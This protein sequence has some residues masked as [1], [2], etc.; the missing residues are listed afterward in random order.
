MASAWEMLNENRLRGTDYLSA[1]QRQARD[2]AANF[3]FRNYVCGSGPAV[4]LNSENQPNGDVVLGRYADG[5]LTTEG[6]AATYNAVRVRVQ[7]SKT[8]NSEVPFFFARIFGI[9]SEASSAEAVAM[10]R[11]GIS[12]FRAT[13]STG[14]TS[15]LPFALDIKEWNKLLA[16]SGPDNWGYDPTSKQIYSG[17]DGV[18]EIKLYPEKKTASGITPGNFGTIDIGGTDNSNSVLKRQI[19]DGVSAED[20]AYHGGEL[21]LDP[22][23]Q[24]LTLNGETGLSVGMDLALPDAV[25]EARTIPLYSKVVSG[26]NTAQFTIVAF[27]GVRILTFDLNGSNKYIMIQPAVVVDDSAI[28]SNSP[29]SYNVYQPVMLVQ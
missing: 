23:S 20:L 8:R 2:A 25:G 22:V 6:G 21:K 19:S 26:G 15:L 14:N 17:G 4:D 10:F 11:D 1:V 3:A 29:T 13:R 5:T 28:S 9:K 27:V 16:G 24:T 12:G 18:R 7:R